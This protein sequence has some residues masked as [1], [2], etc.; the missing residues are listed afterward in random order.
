MYL[1]E[2]LP[3]HP[4]S[5]NISLTTCQEPPSLQSSSEIP[6]IGKQIWKDSKTLITEQNIS[7]IRLLMI[8]IFYALNLK[9]AELTVD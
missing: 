7:K 8:Q 5:Q 9:L 2:E 6:G 3:I 4:F 1:R